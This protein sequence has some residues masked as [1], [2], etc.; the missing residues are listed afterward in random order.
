MARR[1]KTCRVL[2][3]MDD[4]PPGKTRCLVCSLEASPWVA[5]SGLVID[6]NRNGDRILRPTPAMVAD[7]ARVRAERQERRNHGFA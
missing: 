6:G 4:L 3:L 1:C 2:C 5:S 7:D